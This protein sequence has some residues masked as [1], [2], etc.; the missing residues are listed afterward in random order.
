MSNFHETG[1]PLK[2]YGKNRPISPN[3]STT[4]EPM[5]TNVSALVEALYGD[6]KTDKSFTVVQGAL[7]W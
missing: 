7:L 6:Y 5:F 4:T 2:R 3:I 1:P